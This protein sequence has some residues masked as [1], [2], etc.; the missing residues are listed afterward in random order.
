[1]H[2]K[3]AADAFGFNTCHGDGADGFVVGT[4]LRAVMASGI[5]VPAAPRGDRAFE[6][7]IET[8]PSVPVIPATPPPRVG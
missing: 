3:H 7:T 5:A 8:L 2:Q 6:Q 4:P 1:M